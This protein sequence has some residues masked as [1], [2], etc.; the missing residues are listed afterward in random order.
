MH[1]YAKDAVIDTHEFL[2]DED[3]QP[4]PHIWLT[5]AEEDLL[6]SEHVMYPHEPLDPG[7]RYRVRIVGQYRGGPLNLEWTFTTR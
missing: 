7:T 2:R 4:L 1:V 6:S 3:A 5:P